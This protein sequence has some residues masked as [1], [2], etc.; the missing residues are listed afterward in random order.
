[1]TL[2]DRISLVAAITSICALLGIMSAVKVANPEKCL[3][4]VSVFLCS[5]FREPPKPPSS[6][7]FAP[8][9]GN[10]PHNSRRGT[11]FTD[12]G[13]GG[14]GGDGGDGGNGVDPDWTRGGSSS[15]INPLYNPTPTA[16]PAPPAP[17]TSDTT[18]EEL[19]PPPLPSGWE[20]CVDETDGMTYFYH[21]ASQHSQWHRPTEEEKGGEGG[22]A[23]DAHHHH[24]YNSSSS[25][26]DWKRGGESEELVEPFLSPFHEQQPGST[27]YSPSPPLPT[28]H[29]EEAAHDEEESGQVPPGHTFTPA[30]PPGWVVRQSTHTGGVYYKHKE[31]NVSQWTVPLY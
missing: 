3:K 5:S 18:L 7:N 1:M 11:P 16:P 17:P 26:D 29:E 2:T 9:G 24:H 12:G 28:I 15:N 30:L 27:F 4:R 8:G 14:D 25:S 19:A 6:G 21:A 23:G 22:E 20:E 31:R 13:N 10:T